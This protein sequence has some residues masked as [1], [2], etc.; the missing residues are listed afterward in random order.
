M[1]NQALERS[2][3]HNSNMQGLVLLMENDRLPVSVNTNHNFNTV[4]LFSFKLIFKYVYNVIIFLGFHTCKHIISASWRAISSS[5]LNLR[6]R[7]SKA[8]FGQRTKLSFFVPNAN[9]NDGDVI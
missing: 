4:S 6:V 1:E 9:K 8:D 5:I 7:H 2:V 3:H